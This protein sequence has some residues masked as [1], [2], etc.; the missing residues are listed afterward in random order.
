M[1]M[2]ELLGNFFRK[3]ND[4]GKIE[5]IQSSLSRQGRDFHVGQGMTGCRV[6]L[7]TQNHGKGLGL[8]VWEAAA[9]M[10]NAGPV[11]TWLWVQ[12]DLSYKASPCCLDG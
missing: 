7:C 2:L 10:S 9:G 8:V 12:I 4:L 3:N 5:L 11:Y 1:V 6:L